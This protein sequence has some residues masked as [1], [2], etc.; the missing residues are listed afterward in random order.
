MAAEADGPIELLDLD[1]VASALRARTIGR[2]LHYARATTSTM[3]DA[4]RLARGGCAHGAVAVAD[5]QAAGRGTKG[6]AWVS[7]PGEGIH[8]TLILRPDALR[9]QRL[10]I[11][12]AVAAAR[13]IE[14]CTPLRAEL[15]WPNDIELGGRKAGGILIEADW[16]G[17]GPRFA[18]AGIGINVNFDPSPHAALIDRPATSLMVEL[19]RRQSREDVL[20]ALLNEFED[21]YEH[22]DGAGVFQTWR[23]RL[24]T[25]GRQVEI[26]GPAGRVTS[27]T[28]ED[29]E[30]DGALL[31]R[32]ADGGLD[33]IV[34]G[35]VTLRTA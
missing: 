35:E 3:D 27:G 21:A 26:H 25:L 10:S 31:V 4:R 30:P 9:M 11:I 14:A 32:R 33:R 2:E 12:A 5:E 19:G 24:S 29:V 13:A 15:K 20:A 23:E 6:R 17:T 34:A 1:R 28:A 8:A 7:P 18:L 22:W 16:G